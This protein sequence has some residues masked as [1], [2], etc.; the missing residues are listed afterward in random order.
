[1]TWILLNKRW[2]LII[3]LSLLYLVQIAYTYHLVGKL[4]AADQKCVAQIKEIEHKQ[5]K[6]LAEAQNKANKA[7]ADYEQIKAEQ[8][9]K[10]ETVTRTVQKIVERPIYQRDCFDASGLSEIN[11]LIKNDSARE[12]NLY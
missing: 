5:V 4:K 12:S 3:V 6:A 7:S 8:R 11:S 1:M 10:V 2:S 9:A